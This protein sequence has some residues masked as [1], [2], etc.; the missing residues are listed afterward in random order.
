MATALT[1][2]L[3]IAGL[4][5]LALG[6]VHLVLPVL[7]D[8]EHAIPTTGAPLAP[9]RLGPIRYATTRGD[10]RGIAWVMN[11]AAS[12][13]LITVGIADL[14][15]L[16]WPTGALGSL[17]ALWIASW[18]LIRALSQLYLG[19]RPGDLRIVAGF[20]LLALLHLTAAFVR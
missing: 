20:A 1:I 4:F 16:R 7:F 9:L 5:T 11:H 12:Y 19:H 10:V 3:A 18:W 8:F 15:W 6:I 13:V 17:L 14:L 2:A